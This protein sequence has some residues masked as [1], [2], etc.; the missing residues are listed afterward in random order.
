MTEQQRK[1]DWCQTFTGRAIYPL[2]MRPEDIDLRD[3]AHSLALQCRFTGHCRV[4]Y[5]VAD[6][7]LRVLKAVRDETCGGLMPG[8]EE[9]EQLR[10]A[11]LHDAAEAY[12]TDISRPVKRSI[13]GWQEIERAI[14]ATIAA[15]FELKL[16]I[17][18]IVLHADS[19][20]LATEARDL[21]APP[22]QSW[23]PLPAPLPYRI[24]PL[25]WDVA[26]ARFLGEAAS[27][28]L[29]PATSTERKFD[30]PGDQWDLTILSVCG[31]PVAVSVYAWD[32]TALRDDE[33]GWRIRLELPREYDL[34]VKR[35]SGG[36][37]RYT[38]DVVPTK[39]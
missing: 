28:E 1:G 35:S 23:G 29:T 22:P 34:D 4:P 6:H 3:I 17:P 26:E 7:S 19:V 8:E 36:N 38:Y 9:R 21:M 13:Q 12:M 16:P 31:R 30:A 5:Y 11:L 20:L 39:G 24:H 10:W 25:P 14:E 37:G 27:L 2:D 33:M 18:E 15:R 32:T